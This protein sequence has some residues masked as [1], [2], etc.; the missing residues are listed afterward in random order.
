MS[1]LHPVRLH[2]KGKFQ[3][4]PSTVNNDPNHFNNATFDR[5]K[6][7]KQEGGQ[8]GGWWNPMGDASWRLIGC[9]VTSAWVGADQPVAATD[10]VLAYLLADSDRIV[11][12]KIVDLDPEQQMVS[13][14][15][16]LQVRLAKAD[17]TTVLRGDFAT[18]PFTD[19]WGRALGGNNDDI[20]ACAAYQSVLE[21]LEWGDIGNSLFLHELKLQSPDA[22]LSIKFDVDGYNLTP[23][24]A[25]FTLG[26]IV[27]TIGP[28]TR[29][30]PRH[31]TLGRHLMAAPVAPGGFFV[32]AGKINFCEA[33]VNEDAGKTYLDLGNSLPTTVPGGPLA[34][35]GSLELVYLTQDDQGNTVPNS[36]GKIGYL[37]DGWYEQTAGVVALPASG[38][39][40]SDQLSMIE[41]NQLALTLT[42]PTSGQSQVAISEPA[43]GAY[44][45]ADEFVFR[46]NPGDRQKATLYAT[47]WGKPFADAL[48][49]NFFD[50]SQLQTP[51]P[52]QPTSAVSFPPTVKTN[53]DGIAVLEISTRDPGNPR[54]FIDGQVFGV[55]SVLADS[56]A[57]A[58]Q[59]PVNPS[60]FISILL[61]GGFTSD[62]PPTWFGSIQPLLQQYANLY[63]V[64]SRFLDLSDYDSVCANL[65]PLRRAFS[66]PLTDPDSMPVTR[67]LSNAKRKAILTWLGPEGSTERP[68][69][70]T[71]AP[72]A[73]SQAGKRAQ[74]PMG[75]VVATH[76]GKA[77]AAARRLILRWH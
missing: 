8:A 30:E 14:V 32:P 37:A 42:D 53:A 64:M 63:P 69:K 73:A 48:I 56:L 60:D 70:G 47:Q 38:R 22:L 41:G 9:K 20:N 3:A 10:P 45:R 4:A 59:Y 1:Y 62:S 52:P 2:F 7:W 55:R 25:D 76:G 26:R 50:P 46:M 5:T 27:G 58:L 15:W 49:F 75:A 12:A 33:M 74:I 43:D 51:A 40:S 34:D 61:W 17:G 71:P 57:Y 21:N 6:D 68:L 72:A 39:F 77:A 36:L 18:A 44:L 13:Q 65:T 16:G 24:T 29:K 11:A 54:I 31:F 23:G 19:I 35:L 66:L 28:C 67:D